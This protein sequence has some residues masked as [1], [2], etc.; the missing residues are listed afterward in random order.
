MPATLP[1]WLKPR[2]LQG[3]AWPTLLLWLYAFAL[4]L[5]SIWHPEGALPPGADLASR[6]AFFLILSFWVTADA[7]KRHHPLCYDYDSFVFFLWPVVVP[8]YLL[9]TRGWRALLTGLC[10]L[11]IWVVMMVGLGVLF[12]VQE[13]AQGD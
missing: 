5:V 12:F 3:M 11:G 6:A 10:F 7:R 9:R 8:V 13:L 1:N 2:W 4:S